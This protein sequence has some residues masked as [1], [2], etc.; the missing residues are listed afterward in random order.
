VRAAKH[1]P[2][3]LPHTPDKIAHA[4]IR[5]QKADGSGEGAFDTRLE[6]QPTQDTRFTLTRP[7]Q[8]QGRNP[9]FDQR[10]A[11]AVILLPPAIGTTENDDDGRRH[12][13]A[14]PHQPAI[15]SRATTRPP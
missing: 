9:T 3:L 2:K 4:F 8:Q 14:R 7:I 10:Q 13:A 12:H 11:G 5:D 15:T 1:P 6:M